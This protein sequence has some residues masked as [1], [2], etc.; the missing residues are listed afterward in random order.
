M[1]RGGNARNEGMIVVMGVRTLRHTSGRNVPTRTS[2][3]FGRQAMHRGFNPEVG[4][5]EVVWWQ[6]RGRV[7]GGWQTAMRLNI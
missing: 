6:R 1:A 4:V 5:E 2:P 7:V 3:T